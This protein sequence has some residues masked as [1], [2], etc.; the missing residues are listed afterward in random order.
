M[1]LGGVFGHPLMDT[2]IYTHYAKAGY[3]VVSPDY[4]LAPEAPSPA[5]GDDVDA[6]W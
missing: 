6:T 2:A 5:A 1:L 4:R 3:S